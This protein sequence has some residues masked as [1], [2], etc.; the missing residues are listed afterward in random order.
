MSK[1]ERSSATPATSS[2]AASSVS[3]EYALTSCT[4]TTR[5]SSCACLA[6]LATASPAARE[7]A[8]PSVASRTR[9]G[10]EADNPWFI[11]LDVQTVQQGCFPQPSECPWRE[12]RLDVQLP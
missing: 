1:A 6:R 3:V 12:P 9:L 11:E 5:T 7:A 4:W 2:L 8:E 10:L